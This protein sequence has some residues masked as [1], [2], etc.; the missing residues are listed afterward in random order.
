MNGLTSTL[1]TAIVVASGCLA[2]GG[3]YGIGYRPDGTETGRQ[4]AAALLLAPL[5][6][7]LL[8]RMP[9]DVR[10]ML[11]AVVLLLAVPAWH[12]TVFVARLALLDIWATAALVAL[13]MSAV[14]YIGLLVRRRLLA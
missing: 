8:L 5:L 2:A 4:L 14:V 6:P 7:F 9:V 10:P 1:L 12:A 13:A 11:C 3:S